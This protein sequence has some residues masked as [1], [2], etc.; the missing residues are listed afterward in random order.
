M[1]NTFVNKNIMSIQEAAHDLLQLSISENSRFVES[2]NSVTKSERMGIIKTGKEFSILNDS[3]TD[4]CRKNIFDD[5]AVRPQSMEKV[6]LVD[7]ATKYQCRT[8]NKSGIIPM[9][10]KQKILR[11]FHYKKEKDAD[12]YF[13]EQLLL[14]FPWRDELKEIENIAVDEKY[15]Q[16]EAIIMNN[17]QLCEDK[18]R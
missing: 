2:I 3:S 10:A 6:C 17:Q 1:A 7:F 18:S 16:H 14:F 12:K 4:V 8:I 11:Y 5:Y 13:K 15:S 9:R